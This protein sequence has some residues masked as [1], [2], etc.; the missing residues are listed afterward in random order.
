MT[1]SALL[2]PRGEPGAPL[3]LVLQALPGVALQLVQE[4]GGELARGALIRAGKC[5]AATTTEVLVT[6]RRPPLSRLSPRE[7][8]YVLFQLSPQVKIAIGARVKRP[9]EEMITEPAELQVVHRPDGDEM[10][11]YERLLGEA[12]EGDPTLFAREDAV[13]AAWEVVEPILGS[14]DARTR[15]R[16]RKLGAGGGRGARG[17]GRRVALRDVLMRRRPRSKR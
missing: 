16:A 1:A 9:G 15:V 17:R 14:D 7:T 10:D 4:D 3:L 5:L 8:N 6:L 13:E 2:R 12:M 11:A